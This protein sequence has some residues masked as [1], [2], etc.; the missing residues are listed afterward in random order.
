MTNIHKKLAL[1][2]SKSVKTLS[3]CLG[4]IWEIW[5]TGKRITIN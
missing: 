4:Y 2:R 1:N 3:I 5:K